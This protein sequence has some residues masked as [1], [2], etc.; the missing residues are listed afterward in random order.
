MRPLSGLIKL[1]RSHVDLF[2]DQEIQDLLEIFNKEL[3]DR[4]EDETDE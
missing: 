4:H 2:T 3:N 1:I